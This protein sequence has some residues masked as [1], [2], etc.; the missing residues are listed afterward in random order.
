MDGRFVIGTFARLSEEKGHRYLIRAIKNVRNK[1]PNLVCLIVGEGGERAA[2][3]REVTEA[4]VA[5]IVQLTGWRRDG[6]KNFVIEKMIREYETA[7]LRAMG[8]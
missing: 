8:V 2:I 5:D 4:G 3:E 7:Y 6:I 1:I